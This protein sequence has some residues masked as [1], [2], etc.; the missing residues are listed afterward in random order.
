MKNKNKTEREM[1]EEIAKLWLGHSGVNYET[2]T[3]EKLAELIKDAV[4]GDKKELQ[5][6]KTAFDDYA[7][8]NPAM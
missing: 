4:A 6:E 2:T 5:K 3:S 1:L 7:F 8:N